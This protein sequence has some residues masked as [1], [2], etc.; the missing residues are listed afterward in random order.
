MP[1]EINRIMCDHASTLLFSPTVTGLNN[2]INEGFKSNDDHKADMDHPKIYH[3]EE[4]VSRFS[5]KL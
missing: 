1:E 3:S 5:N 2:L 4:G